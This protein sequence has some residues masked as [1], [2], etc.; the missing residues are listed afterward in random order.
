MSDDELLLQRRRPAGSRPSGGGGGDD[1]DADI[2]G[3]DR[4]PATMARGDDVAVP[5]LALEAAE[6]ELNGFWKYFS[7]ALKVLFSMGLA[8]SLWRNLEEEDSKS[9]RA[10]RSLVDLFSVPNVALASHYWNVGLA[11]NFLSTPVTYYLVDSLD[12]SA[13]VINQYSALTYLPWCLKVFIGIYSDSIPL[14]GQHRKPYFVIGWVVFVL[15]CGWLALYDE[16]SV[17]QVN[18]LSALMVLGYILSDVVA[19]ALIVERSVY[20]TKAELGLMRTEGYVIRSVGGVTGAV[21]GT[22]LYN[23]ASWGWGLTIGQCCLLQA[24]IPLLTL[25]PLTP[26]LLDTGGGYQDVV[27]A[28]RE[29][30]QLVQRRT[31][32]WPMAF[33]YMYSVLQIANPAWTNFLVEGLGFENYEIGIIT[34]ASSVF[35]WAALYVYKECFFGTNWQMIYYFT[36]ALNFLLSILQ[37]LL[38]TGETG[39]VPKLLFATGDVAFMAFVM[40]MQ[41]RSTV[42][43]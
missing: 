33:I 14:A 15:S 23:K 41:V 17:T 25:A 21:L 22:I 18:Y 10:R 6:S 29:I 42:H 16:P 4:D 24:A 43:Q 1:D 26:W 5:L 31:V 30:W 40:Y 8:P 11:L 20:E 38:V 27:T 19:D 32:W 34:I 28:A 13:A 2:K 37:V 7:L 9:R 35:S 12:A 36:T 39:S 3:G